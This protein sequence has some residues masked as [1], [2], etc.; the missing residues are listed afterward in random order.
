[1]N[2][3]GNRKTLSCALILFGSAVLCVNVAHAAVVISSKPTANMNCSG[4]VCTPTSKNAVLNK[5]DLANMLASGDVTVKSDAIAQDIEIDAKL[6]W[7]NSSR[8]A[9]DSYRSI[10]FAKPIV[11]GTNGALTITTN[12]GSADGDFQ[13]LK[14]GHVEFRSVNSNLV[15]NGH[16]YTL[17]QNI[18]QISRTLSGGAQYVAVSRDIDSA[19]QQFKRAPIYELNATLEGLGNTISNLKVRNRITSENVGLISDITTSGLV[20]DLNLV[21]ADITGNADD[22][23]LL[24]A[25]AGKNEGTVLNVNASGVVASTGEFAQAGGLIGESSGIIRRCSAVTSVSVTNEQSEAGG[26]VGLVFEQGTSFPGVVDQSYAEGTVTASATA[27]SNVNVGGLIG[28]AAGGNTSNS[29]S[30][31]ATSVGAGNSS[32]SAGGLIG[33]AH[34]GFDFPLMISNSYSTGSV[35]GP[36][37]A[38]LGGVVGYIS[39]SQYQIGNA[40]WDI[41]TTGMNQGCAGTCTG[42]SGLSDEQLKSGLPAGFDKKVWTQDAAHNSGYPYLIDNP[43]PY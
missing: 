9:L 4:G 38:I 27:T 3:S 2:L 15:I 1:M 39:P 25:L 21:S 13:F 10:T 40:Y 18:R 23:Q 16:I 6:S 28:F 11:V 41:D 42:V 22:D 5:D 8:L 29:Y 32:L 37:G 26:L 43:P 33:E 36:D 17:G 34:E 7:T 20:R 12:D 19:D 30:H 31:S 14:K 35:S 24:G